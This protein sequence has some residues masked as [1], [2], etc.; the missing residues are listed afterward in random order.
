MY[1]QSCLTLCEPVDCSPPSYSVHGISQ[2]RILE[3]VAISFSRGSSWPKDRTHISYITGRFFTAELPGISG[4]HC[5]SAGKE[6]ACNVEDLGSIPGLGRSPGEGN[7]VPT[8]VFWPGEFLGQRSLAGYSPVY[9]ILRHVPGIINVDNYTK[10]LAYF[11][12][13]H[14]T[15]CCCCFATNCYF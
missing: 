2:A 13:L 12:C 11:H 14:V 1:A 15:N 6:S 8:P 4:F 9:K 10:M 3:W 5:G 7:R